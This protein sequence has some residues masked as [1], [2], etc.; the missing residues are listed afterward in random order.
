[1][2]GPLELNDIEFTTKTTRARVRHLLINW[3]PA[4]LLDSKILIQKLGLRD[5][6]Y[7]ILGS[8]DGSTDLASQLQRLKLP[9]SLQAK[10]I[11]VESV[12]ILSSPGAQTVR[13]DQ[14]NAAL[15]LTRMES[16][17]HS[18]PSPGLT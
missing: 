10:S 4:Q 3:D 9:F 17:L 6:H 5:V 11:A 7:T 16:T 2:L 1:M 13:I 8:A 15:V 12:D 18:C 14:A